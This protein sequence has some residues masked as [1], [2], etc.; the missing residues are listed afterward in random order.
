MIASH[1]VDSSLSSFFG[2]LAVA[3]LCGVMA[4]FGRS[5]KNELKPLKEVPSIIA[6]QESIER[7]INLVVDHV[8]TLSANGGTSLRDSIDRNER[9]TSEILHK[10]NE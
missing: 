4:W 6:R 3:V 10:V 9:M 8:A 5:I 1:L 7:S 2:G